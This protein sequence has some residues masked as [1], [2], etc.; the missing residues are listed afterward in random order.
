MSSETTG[1]SGFYEFLAWLE[2]N[3]KRLLIAFLVAIVAGFGISIY[4]WKAHETELAA[5]DALLKLHSSANPAEKAA[6][7]SASD[8]L[9]V[10]DEY[11]HT[12]A[13]ERALL[14]GA[15]TLFTESKYPE[16]QA[17]FEQFLKENS[18]SPL[19]ATS[20]YGRAAALEAQGK[21]DDAL[22]AYQ[23]VV[24]QYPRA[25]LVN[26]ARFATARIYEAKK[27]PELAL[28]TYEDMSRTNSASTKA[29]EAMMRKEHLF[30]KYPEL[31]K[32]SAAA[33]SVTNQPAML[34]PDVSP[35]PT[36]NTLVVPGTNAPVS[37]TSP[38]AAKP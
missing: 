32:T 7:S 29:T 16:A 14:L 31:A 6:P 36:A 4:R 20:A 38:P 27:Q 25:S 15:G 17:K 21:L 2:E 8:Y 35:K 28:K 37:A 13:A 1:S 18:G 34:A 10:A 23:N 22:S 11:P 30:T 33:S 26:D 5:S 24:T 12:D 9:K 3:K 19:A